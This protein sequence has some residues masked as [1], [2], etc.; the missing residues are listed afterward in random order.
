M[1]PPTFALRAAVPV[2]WGVSWRCLLCLAPG[3]GLAACSDN[4]QGVSVIGVEPMLD[5]E[6][7]ESEPPGRNP[8][9]P[10]GI[11]GESDGYAC[12]DEPMDV[13]ALPPV[14]EVVVDTSGSMNW[15][16][17]TNRQARPGER[18]K[19]Q[20]TAEALDAALEL[21][22]NNAG[23]GMTYYP[24]RQGSVNNCFD[25]DFGIPIAA[26]SADQRERVRVA[27]A[28]V[29]PAGGT[30][31]YSAYSSG[32][33]QLLAAELA[34]PKFMLLITDG[35]ATYATNCDQNVTLPM[36]LM[37]TMSNALIGGVRTFVIGS[38][39]SQSAR[40]EL[41]RMAMRGG[42]AHQPCTDADAPYCHFDVSDGDAFE[43][44]LRAALA[45]V[46]NAAMACE[47]PL[48]TPP[49]GLQLDLATL[50]VHFA[51]S[52]G[53]LQELSPTEAAECS[54]GWRL[55]NDQSRIVLC[56]ASCSSV[57]AN[58]EGAAPRLRIRFACTQ[59]PK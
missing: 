35:P 53:N 47:Y 26:L 20:V 43:A 7:M 38:P 8:D 49:P 13:T 44:D 10:M 57:H 40:G 45:D 9:R 46:V 18:S 25:P 2:V 17:G 55:S 52:A 11:F 22:P 41:S 48:P 54:S 59:L 39:G 36:S 28:G 34:G 5:S 1:P 15:V 50:A 14:L 19:W 58:A 6:V 3:A 42:T 37:Q 24:N 56:P 51:D 21:M 23:V 27:N 33:G 31:T 29:V 30:P 12:Q 16:P 4:H 32:L